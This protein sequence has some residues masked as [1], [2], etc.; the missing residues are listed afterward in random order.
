METAIQETQTVLQKVDAESCDT[1]EIDEYVDFELNSL[2]F[3]MLNV[4]FNSHKVYALSN[5][6]FINKREIPGIA[7]GSQRKIYWTYA[8]SIS[9]NRDNVEIH[10]NPGEGLVERRTLHAIMYV[11]SLYL[12][13]N[14]NTSH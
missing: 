3:L 8:S 6:T 5:V 10:H 7:H 4:Y 9:S 14:T 12:I 1:F 2:L 13:R 11:L